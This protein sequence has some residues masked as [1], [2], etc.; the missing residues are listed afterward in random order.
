MPL[1]FILLIIIIAYFFVPP[2]ITQLKSISTSPKQR[3]SL[4]FY[5]GFIGEDGEF[6]TDSTT[7]AKTYT[8]F[9]PTESAKS[10]SELLQSIFTSTSTLK[11]MPAP[12]T[13]G[14]EQEA[15]P[16]VPEASDLQKSSTG[17]PDA[18]SLMGV[19]KFFAD[20]CPVGFSSIGQLTGNGMKCGDIEY[21]T[22][23]A[24]AEISNGHLSKIYIV[25]PGSGYT[26]QNPPK[27]I[28]NDASS[29]RP[30]GGVTLKTTVDGTGA[31]TQ[32]DIIDY[33]TGL[34]STP[35]I[36]VEPP[37]MASVCNMCCPTTPSSKTS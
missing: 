26:S 28:A 8:I 27:A 10:R 20:A 30:I 3:S 24:I 6:Q 32:I 2:K 34:E 16:S 22:T 15:G 25:K 13:V 12:T 1:L 33:G 18:K 11:D 17:I 5:E 31:L 14:K 7:A 23:E 36:V 21:I 9:P 19:C 4:P 29:G 37:P 35:K